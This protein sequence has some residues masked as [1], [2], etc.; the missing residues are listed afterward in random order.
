[1]LLG[2]AWLEVSSFMVVLGQLWVGTMPDSKGQLPRGNYLLLVAVVSVRPLVFL[3]A[4]SVLLGVPVALQGWTDGSLTVNLIVFPLVL[5]LKNA[6]FEIAR[7]QS[8][9]LNFAVVLAVGSVLL[10]ALL[11]FLYLLVLLPAALLLVAVA[12]AVFRPRIIRLVSSQAARLRQRGRK[13]G[14]SAV[15]QVGQADSGQDRRA[16][17]REG[18]VGPGSG[19]F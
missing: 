9:L 5:F 8:W 13:Q 17:P 3:A 11:R 15:S 7:E 2:L 12:A 4:Q 18:A 16:V 19:A 10:Y 1:M 14:Q 6:H